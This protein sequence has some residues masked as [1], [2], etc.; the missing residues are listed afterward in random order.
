MNMSYEFHDAIEDLVSGCN[1]ENCHFGAVEDFSFRGAQAEVELLLEDLQST[2][3]IRGLLSASGSPVPGKYSEAEAGAI[4]NFL[5]VEGDRSLGIHNR[6]YAVS[7]LESSLTV[8][9]PL[10]S[11]SVSFMAHNEAR[12]F[13]R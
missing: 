8:L 11:P 6:Q 1:A 4:F 9:N 5:F 3:T 7:L 2:L 12:R 13:L 10:V